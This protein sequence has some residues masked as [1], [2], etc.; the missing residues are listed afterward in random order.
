MKV[1]FY[2]ELIYEL[3][4]TE[5]HDKTRGEGGE[6]AGQLIDWIIFRSLSRR[7]EEEHG[8]VAKK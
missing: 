6:A 7:Q 5:D 3:C 2:S 8:G 1:R 4:S